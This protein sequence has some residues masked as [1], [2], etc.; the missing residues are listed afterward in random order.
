MSTNIS[1]LNIG[2]QTLLRYADLDY[3]EWYAMSEF[4]DNS[5]HSYLE[6]AESLK[7]IN[8]ERCNVN[9][10]IEGDSLENEVINVHDDSG[11]IHPQEFPRLLSLGMKKDKAETQLSEFGMGMKTAAFWFG[12]LIEIETKHYLNDKCYKII[13]DLD[14]L[15]TD[16]EVE[17]IECKPS[18]NK[19][20]YTKLK[21]SKLNRRLNRKKKKIRESLA[22]IY[23]KFIEDG[24]L[25]I[26]FEGDTIQPYSFTL[27][28]TADGSDV[29][30][31]FVITLKNGKSAKGWIGQ[32][33]KGKALE[34]G[35]SVYR[36]DRLI[37]G[38][39]ENSWRPKGIFGQEG[40]S[41]DLS[42]QRLVGELDMSEFN[43]AHTK[44]KVNFVGEEEEEFRKLLEKESEQIKKLASAY[45]VKKA[46]KTEDDHE[47]EVHTQI[48]KEK[49]KEFFKKPENIDTTSIEFI[50]PPIKSKTFEKVKD[51]YE[52]RK[53]FHDLS[54]L[55][56]GSIGK[57]VLVYHFRE[58]SWPYMILDEIEE[59]L[60]VCINIAHPYFIERDRDAE[61]LNEFM[62]NC[63]F[64][65]LVEV[66]NIAKY[67][68]YTPE[69]GRLTKDI[70]LKR[71]IDDLPK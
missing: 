23:R 17:V 4:V 12:R 13:I 34:S 64:D 49:V 24:R 44:N 42:F 60:C 67:G 6:N 22:S 69:D 30:S 41:N 57:A 28:K 8:V 66:H 27:M 38:Y 5:L 25:V 3:D 52:N 11:G 47:H 43:V 62:I 10:S 46:S 36:F 63:I 45:R 19:K 16:K 48:A 9:I 39:P 20:G 2:S 7:K 61:S 53:P 56:Q 50:A 18:S 14:K 68:E 70:F 35:F 26:N 1:K 15:G 55:A 65:A 59:K 32:R 71:W 21:V 54:H 58:V 31:D 33:F 40:G 29:R 51:I 37:M